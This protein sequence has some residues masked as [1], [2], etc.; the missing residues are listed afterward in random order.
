M[1]GVFRVIGTLSVVKRGSRRIVFRNT[2]E[3]RNYTVYINMMYILLMC[4]TIIYNNNIFI[5][6]NGSVRQKKQ[7]LVIQR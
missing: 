1:A 7:T 2:S 4:Y 6:L 3:A 5:V